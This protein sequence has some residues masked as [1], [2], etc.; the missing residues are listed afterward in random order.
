MELHVAARDRE[1]ARARV[2]AEL[3]E[4]VVGVTHPATVAVYSLDDELL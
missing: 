1:Q 3:R 4:L 2:V